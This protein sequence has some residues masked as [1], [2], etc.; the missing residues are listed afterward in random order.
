MAGPQR[1][2][3]PGQQYYSDLSIWDVYRCQVCWRCNPSPFP[4][5]VC[6]C[7]CVCSCV[8]VCVC[9]CVCL[10]VCVFVCPDQC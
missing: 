8:C 6:V 1:V 2:Q 4:V 7:S 9:V 5:C 3:E 10:C